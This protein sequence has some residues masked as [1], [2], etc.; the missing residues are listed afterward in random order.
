MDVIGAY[1]PKRCGCTHVMRACMCT[2]D[3]QYIDVLYDIESVFLRLACTT[4]SVARASLDIRMEGGKVGGITGP[5]C[6][7]MH[8]CCESQSQ[9]YRKRTQSGMPAALKNGEQAG[10]GGRQP[11]KPYQTPPHDPPSC[12]PRFLPPPLIRDHFP[13]DLQA[14]M[15]G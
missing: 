7:A 1:M 5:G 15:D 12:H 9:S 2:C 14:T 11:A 3:H 10:P 4:G 13:I 8:A 6:M